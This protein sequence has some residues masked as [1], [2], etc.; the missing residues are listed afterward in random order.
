MNLI[1]NARAGVITP[2][3]EQVAVQEGVTPEFVRQG[4]A[5]GTIVILRNARRQNVTPVGVGK[6]LRT[7]VSASVG[8]Y[9][10]MGRID[11]EIAK[12]KAAVEAGTD[13]IMDLSVSGDIEAMLAETLAV[14]PKPVG[15]LPLYQAMAEAGRKYG[16]SV[17]M[18]DEDLESLKPSTGSKVV[19]TMAGDHGVVEEGV[20]TCPQRVT[21]Q[22][23][24]NFV[25][26]G[27]GINALAGAAGARVVVVDMGVAGDLKDL[28][29]QGKILSRKVDYGTRNMTRGPAM[30]RQQAV[31]ALETGIN[32]AGDL[33]NEGVE[34]LGTGDM[35]IGNTTPSSAILENYGRP[36]CP[37]NSPPP[38]KTRAVLRD[39]SV[40]LLL[41]GEPP[42][43]D[44]QRRVLAA[45]REAFKA[46]YYK[47]IAFWAGPCALCPSCSAAD[48]CRHPRDARPSMEG[49]GIDVY[50]TGRRAGHS[51]RTLQDRQNYVKYFA[52]LLLE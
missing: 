35:G 17:K 33:V 23:V 43:R 8:L 5:E 49:S 48:Q 19:V 27:A 11:V 18:R 16:S 24:Y 15:T 1:K 6:G 20:S 44:F 52:L 31:Q 26:G 10:E 13:A 47:A 37:P 21:L 2:E 25:A 50:E 14:S 32:I 45:E 42:A 30:T 46:G 29:E 7:K 51:F 36:H 3:M 41:E 9:G 28:V 40:A 22:M 38:E 12:I 39:F 4:V 34:L